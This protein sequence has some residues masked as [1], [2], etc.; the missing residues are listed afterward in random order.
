MC[1]N[2]WQGSHMAGEGT[3][4]RQAWPNRQRGGIRSRQ[5]V[6]HCPAQSLLHSPGFRMQSGGRG[7]CHLGIGGKRSDQGGHLMICCGGCQTA[8]LRT[9]RLCTKS[10]QVMGCQGL[11]RATAIAQG[12]DGSSRR[13]F[14][15]QMHDIQQDGH[16]QGLRGFWPL[17]LQSR[18]HAQTRAHG[19]CWL[20]LPRIYTR[21]LT[22]CKCCI[23][24]LAHLAPACHQKGTAARSPPSFPLHLD[25]PCR[26]LSGP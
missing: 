1:G 6:R 18:L 10:C 11:Y 12:P 5:N 15:E 13:Y 19:S 24:R 16:C 25:V 4:L 3:N 23:L 14:H 9:T 17:S 22:A 8:A 7:S 26:L 2:E 21:P 20:R